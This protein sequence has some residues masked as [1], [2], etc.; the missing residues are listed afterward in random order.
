MFAKSHVGILHDMSVEIEN[1]LLRRNV[2]AI[3]PWHFRVARGQLDRLEHL[4]SRA[5][6][7]DDVEVDIITFADGLEKQFKHI[8]NVL[9]EIDAQLEVQS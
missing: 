4:L 1:E 2:H 3:D 8:A 5:F 6:D 9:S 7:G